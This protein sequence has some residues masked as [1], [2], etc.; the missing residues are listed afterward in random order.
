MGFHLASHRKITKTIAQISVPHQALQNMESLFKISSDIMSF[1]KGAIV[2]S[3]DNLRLHELY[4]EEIN[5]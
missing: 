5:T 4:Q 1:Q 2:N 3:I